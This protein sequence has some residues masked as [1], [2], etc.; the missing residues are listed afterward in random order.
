MCLTLLLANLIL[1]AP[2]P[3]NDS[4]TGDQGIYILKEIGALIFMVAGTHRCNSDN[5]SACSGTTS[6][7]D[8]GSEDFRVSD[9][10]HIDNFIFHKTT[11]LLLVKTANPY[12]IQL[13]GFSKRA[14][15]PYLILSNSTTLTPLQRLFK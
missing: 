1:Q 11:K 8:N 3:R 12:F 9:M 6:I 5:Y 14:T 15:D 4:N 13:H 10:A 2:H 7:C